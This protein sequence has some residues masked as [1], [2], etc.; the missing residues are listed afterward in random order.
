[1]H[2][3][4]CL[5]YLHSVVFMLPFFTVQFIPS[6]LRKINSIRVISNGIKKKD[7]HFISVKSDIN[8]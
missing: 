8:F 5:T 3:K 2:I 7:F 4:L 1:M 6:T